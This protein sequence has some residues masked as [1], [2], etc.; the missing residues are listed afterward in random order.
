[1]RSRV[2]SSLVALTILAA[3]VAP[4]TISAAQPQP[5]GQK[6]ENFVS[7]LPDV[8]PHMSRLPKLDSRLAASARRAA[9]AGPDAAIQTA[10]QNG[11]QTVGASIRIVVQA[12]SRDPSSARAAVATLGGRIEAEYDNLVQALV[13][14]SAI[15]PL[16][17]RAE[18]AL[19]RPPATPVPTVVV[20]EGVSATNATA[21]HTAGVT[22]A[23]IK[24]GIIDLG[25]VNYTARQASGELPASLTTADFCSGQLTTATVH[26]TAVAEI[27]HEMAPDAQLYLICIGTEVQLGQAKD[28]AKAQGIQVVNHSV[29]WFNT[30]RGDGSG[31]PGTPDAIVADARAN[32]IL[33]AN[34][35]GNSAQQHWSG[36]FSD[37]DGN[38]WHNFSGADEGNAFNLANG[39][40][41]C[42]TLK[43]DD[44]PVSSQDYDLYLFRASDQTVLA[45]SI[46]DQTGSQPPTEELCYTNAT[47]ASQVDFLA[48]HRFSA[49]LTPRFDLF[50]FGTGSILQY[51]RA[52]GSI[53][54]PA[55][56]PSAF[57]VGAI[58][59]GIDSLEPYSSQ[60]PSIDGRIKPDI[61]GPD[62]VSSATYGAYAGCGVSGFAGTSAAAPH[63]AGAAALVKQANPGFGA[64]Q[65]QNFLES[66]AHD[67]GTPGKDSAFGAGRLLLGPA[68]VQSGPS[69]S[70]SP[71]TV[72]GG[73][74]V[75]ASWTGST[76]AADWV[77]LFRLTDG[78]RV[79]FR[80]V[81]C[82]NSPGGV[83]PSGSC[84]FPM[85]A[86]AGNYEF[87]L[88]SNNTWNVL[89]T[90][91]TVT[92]SVPT[93]T[94]T[95]SPSTV[96]GGGLVTASWTGSTAAAD[97][98]GL[99]RLSDGARV[100]FRFVNC[101]N[102]PGGVVPSGSC[103]F[104]M[105]AA[106]GNYE[107][108]LLSNN[109]WNV[110]ATSNLVVVN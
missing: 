5:G 17:A 71:S 27:V 2:F 36:P 1:M 62:S 77:G 6:A 80:F 7:H 109:T 40:Q 48:I 19:V 20:G 57:A 60:G 107:F 29:G 14:V 78:A 63:A 30:S 42:A 24:I 12:T 69:I 46:N 84:V 22:G 89:A 101:G 70:A 83:V 54:E 59:W 75:T 38:N 65:L 92:V 39:S 49:T 11:L 104:P 33:W 108:R 66:H 99:F 56:S 10:K 61:V 43:W 74:L 102:S 106:A 67:L 25:F 50:I 31:G 44:W 90:S 79:D 73:G 82:G 110:L 41:V 91:N 68:P 28:Y 37:P 85:P 86:M 45:S 9:E 34:A 21:W 4:S 64:T 26:G 18:V 52:D 93:A 3:G 95:A 72:A 81:N 105:P 58:C 53:T 96:A 13:S 103:V 97:W 32:G 15:E 16:A 100:D 55:S 76:A 51:E 98:V 23:G 47:G 94:V 88:L 35:A 8:P 87:R